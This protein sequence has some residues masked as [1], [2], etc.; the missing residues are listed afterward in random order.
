MATHWYCKISGA[1][2]GPLT[3]QQLKAMAV[4]GRLQPSDEVRQGDTGNWVPASRVK[5]LFDK[6]GKGTPAE[7]PKQGE[8]S[9][10]DAPMVRAKPLEEDQPPSDSKPVQIV[11]EGPSTAPAGAPAPAQGQPPTAQTPPTGVV[12]G[13]TTP[14]AGAASQVAQPLGQPPATPAG[15]PAGQVAPQPAAGAAPPP[16]PEKAAGGPKPPFDFAAADGAVSARASR[17]SRRSA[18]RPTPQQRRRKNLIILAVLLVLTAGLAGG[19]IW[20]GMTYGGDQTA[21]SEPSEEEVDLSDLDIDRPKNV[22]AE[23][24]AAAKAQKSDDAPAEGEAA[25]AGD[26]AGADDG[27]VDASDASIRRGD[28]KVSVRSANIGLPRFDRKVRPS[29]PEEYLIVTLALNN[30]GATKKLDFTGFASGGSISRLVTL[31]DDLGNQYKQKRFRGA[32]VEGQASSESLYPGKQLSDVLVF[33]PPIA[34][35]ETL[36]LRLPAAAFGGAGALKFRI[37]AEMIGQAEPPPEPEEPEQPEAGR[38]D[39]M[40][41]DAIGGALRSA[42]AAGDDSPIPPERTVPAIERG[43]QELEAEEASEAEAGGAM[44]P[45]E[46]PAPDSDEPD[47]SEINRD[48]EELGGGDESDEAHDFERILKG[49][50]FEEVERREAEQRDRRRR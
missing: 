39:E 35:A 13:A 36:K 15:V 38:G 2:R 31:V 25:T 20:F 28:V 43:I 44:E 33:E 37:P 3:S 11:D 49:S 8:P 5:G 26:Q 17:S 29:D 6:S 1:E 42:G 34:K 32:K 47:I 41:G 16:V 24:Y 12:P 22:D 14:Q 30:L 7:K 9:Q 21:S 48:I 4:H 10:A 40:I 46:G 18:N 27:W 19:G 50:K 45:G 23:A